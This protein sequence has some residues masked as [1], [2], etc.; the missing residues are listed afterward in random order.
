[1][2]RFHEYYVICEIGALCFWVQLYKGVGN[3]PIHATGV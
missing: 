3:P 1:M 2:V